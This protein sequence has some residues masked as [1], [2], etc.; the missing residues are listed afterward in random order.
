MAYRGAI[1]KKQTTVL[2]KGNEYAICEPCFEWN[3]GKNFLHVN[4]E[5]NYGHE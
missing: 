1:E 2:M 5:E 3:G 4:Q